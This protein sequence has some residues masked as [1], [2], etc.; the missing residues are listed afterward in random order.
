MPVPKQTQV[1]CKSDP[2]ECHS[3]QQTN[4]LDALLAGI[5]IVATLILIALVFFEYK[6]K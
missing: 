2:T 5:I 1:I 3:V 6:T 4:N